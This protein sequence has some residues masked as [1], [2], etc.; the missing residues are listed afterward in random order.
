MRLIPSEIPLNAPSSG[1]IGLH[2]L[3]KDLPLDNWVALHSVN[4]PEHEYKICGEIDFMVISPLGILVLE[5]KSGGIQNRNGIWETKDR[6]GKI[7]RLRESP[8]DQAKS[9]T[10]SLMERLKRS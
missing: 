9:N 4:L 6:W 10:F 2:K 3:L 7:H 1:E 5:V 8:F